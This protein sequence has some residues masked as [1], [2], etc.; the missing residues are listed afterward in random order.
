MRVQ[1]ISAYLMARRFRVAFSFSG[2]V[3]SFVAKTA[4][5]LA[6][7]FGEDAILYDQYHEAEFARPDLDTY[8]PKL[9]SEQADLIVP[10]F[11]H[12]YE[13]I[14]WHGLEWEAL[15]RLLT[16]T[17]GH[18]IMPACVGPVSVPGLTAGPKFINLDGKTTKQFADLIRRRLRTLDGSDVTRDASSRAKSTSAVERRARVASFG[19]GKTP[20]I[21]KKLPEAHAAEEEAGAHPHKEPDKDNVV[22][23]YSLEHFFHE[24]VLTSNANKILLVA[25]RLEETRA[26]SS[27]LSTRALLTS[28]L[29]AGAE[30][31]GRSHAANWLITKTGLDAFFLRTLIP[32]AAGQEG[33]TF[34]EILGEQIL[35]PFPDITEHLKETLDLA[36]RLA[37]ESA[38]GLEPGRVSVRHLL[39]AI[40]RPAPGGDSIDKFLLSFR[41]HRDPVREELIEQLRTWPVADNPAVWRRLLASP[42]LT[43]GEVREGGLPSYA[44]DSVL[45]EDLLD[46]RREVHAMASLVS[47]WAVEPP[48]SIGL[49]GE[50]GS[51]KSFFMQKVK[52]RVRTIAAGARLSDMNQRDL[53]YYKNIVQVEFN[54]WHYVEGDLCASLVEHIF[55]NLRLG[56]GFDDPDSEEHLGARETRLLHEIEGKT[57]GAGQKEIAAA[58]AGE[59]AEKKRV[60]TEAAVARLEREAGEARERAAKAESESRE[61][62]RLA[63]ERQWEAQESALR[64]QIVTSGILGEIAGSAEL[65]GEAREDLKLLGLTPDRLQTASQLQTALRE[66]SGTWTV[67]AG[68]LNILRRD[69]ARWWLLLWLLLPPL[70]VAGLLGLL[71][72]WRESLLFQ[73]MAGLITTAAALAGLALGAWKRYQPLLRPLVEAAR[74][75]RDKRDTLENLMEAA[76]AECEKQAA[77]L[78]AEARGKREDAD[79]ETREAAR[80]A[81][82]AETARQELREKQEAAARAAEAATAARGEVARLRLEAE[83]LRPTR[84][85]ADFILDR[86]AAVDYRQRLGVPALIRRDFEKLSAMFQTQRKKEIQGTESLHDLS[87]VNRIILYIDDLDRCPPE[88]VVEVLRAIH[89]LLAFPL[90]VVIVAVDARWVKRALRERFS[91][92]LDNPPGEAGEGESSAAFTHTPAATADDYLEKIFQVPFWLRP[93][94]R[95][96][97]ESLVRM[98]TLNAAEPSPPGE[99]ASLPGGGPDSH[100]EGSGSV[101]PEAADSPDGF[102]PGE[103]P[104]AADGTPAG[105]APE[106][107]PEPRPRAL[108]LTTPEQEY[109]VRLATLIGRSPRSVKRFINCYRLLKSTL[110]HEDLVRFEQESNFRP[111]MLLLGMVTGMPG[112]APSFFAWLRQENPAKSAADWLL[113]EQISTDPAGGERRSEMHRLLSRMKENESSTASLIKA[114]ALVERF[115]FNPMRHHP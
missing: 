62:A 46:I 13:K 42:D 47:A 88:K 94:Q 6:G 73:Q 81:A 66:A 97:C 9:Y 22:L 99:G 59:E 8:L 102:P 20:R 41:I 45:G 29:L 110:P 67:L 80:K 83:A 115:S 106:T 43:G 10:V 18:R 70:A 85:I 82:A 104:R 34:N 86:A 30:T 75:L 3:R 109:A 27:G 2:E 61:A 35:S 65:R 107:M 54:A 14:P 11:V 25:W 100:A 68:G 33:R 31:G 24:Y 38:T 32:Q 89:L 103:A 69:K 48:L 91:Q 63:A 112:L 92:L 49:F 28:L 19:R 7:E 101:S 57:A 50:W 93:M 90:F 53:G 79:R 12:E 17:D 72:W 76:R 26:E 114:A 113:D 74:R 77:D 58:R 95:A 98:L 84:R 96:G 36:G 23:A 1:A 105:A 5:L 40:L 52:E 78:D 39:A 21:I 64:R 44:A 56:A 4:A 60:D 16:S 15:H 71:H 37:M 51:G 87:V 108:L 111:A 55:S